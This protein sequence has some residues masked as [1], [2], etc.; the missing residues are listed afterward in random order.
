[1]PA[2]VMGLMNPSVQEVATPLLTV[3]RWF[4]D[5]GPLPADGG[6]HETLLAIASVAVVAWTA[7]FIVRAWWKKTTLGLVTAMDALQTAFVGALVAALASPTALRDVTSAWLIY[8]AVIFVRSWWY[9][10]GPKDRVP[11][12]NKLYFDMLRDADHRLWV[13]LTLLILVPISIV[14]VIPN[15][16]VAAWCA[17]FLTW[18]G[19]QILLIY[20]YHDVV[21]QGA[22]VV[23]S[24]A[25]AASTTPA[26]P[27]LPYEQL[28]QAFNGAV[29]ALD[30]ER[31]MRAIFATQYEILLAAERG[32]SLSA[33]SARTLYDASGQAVAQIPF[34]QYMSFLTQHGLL[35][36]FVVQTDQTYVFNITQKGRDFLAYARQANTQSPA[37]ATPSGST[38]P[39]TAPTVA[40]GVAGS[41]GS[42][43]APQTV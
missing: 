15:R 6:P 25:T 21:A 17:L 23:D 7:G 28:L 41:N 34:E 42:S 9:V 24:Q 39:A 2:V 36:V 26:A 22:P 1:M 31:I 5:A 11:Q 30:F 3:W 38:K 8:Y 27:P 29:L 4:T 12:K 43:D 19:Y 16:G 18:Y 20:V 35:E 10:S 40:D 13:I 37:A 32:G 14:A 33:S